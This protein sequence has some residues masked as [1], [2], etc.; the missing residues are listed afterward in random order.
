METIVKNGHIRVLRRAAARGVTLVE[1]LIVVAIMAVISGGVTL[2]AFP[3]YKEARI[4]TAI[5]GCQTVKQAAD[6]YQNLDGVADQCPTIQ[7][8]ITSKKIDGK[9]S[10]DPWGMPYRIDCSEGEIRVYSN[11]NDRK[12]GT[13]DDLRDDFK[14]AD[15]KRVKDL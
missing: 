7:E 2:V 5:T 9:H 13:P 14:P 8:L 12:P 15:V 11:G 6:L 1:V 4:K 3:L 10:D